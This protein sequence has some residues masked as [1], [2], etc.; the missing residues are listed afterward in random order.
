M[1]CGMTRLVIT[2]YGGQRQGANGTR[3]HRVVEGNKPGTGVVS[4]GVGVCLLCVFL[5]KWAVGTELRVYNWFAARLFK[6]A[7]FS[8][9]EE[10]EGGFINQ[11]I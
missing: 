2:Y 4:T 9:F 1:T 8:L 5:S 7:V 3:G 10:N 6:L 11:N